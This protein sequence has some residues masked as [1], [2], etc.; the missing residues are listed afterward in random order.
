MRCPGL[1]SRSDDVVRSAALD[2]APLIA[3]LLFAGGMREADAREP[4]VIRR[5]ALDGPEVDAGLTFVDDALPG[6]CRI[7]RDHDQTLAVHWLFPRQSGALAALR[8]LLD[9][10]VIVAQKRWPGREIHATFT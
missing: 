4:A 7:E 9:A 10:A 8:L 3:K 6:V 2:D 5:M 1:C